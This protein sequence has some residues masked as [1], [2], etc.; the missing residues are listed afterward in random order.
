MSCKIAIYAWKTFNAATGSIWTNNSKYRRGLE[1][2]EHKVNKDIPL[3]RNK[4]N[5]V[6][7]GASSLW[8]RR[9]SSASNPGDR[10]RRPAGQL[11]KL[12]CYHCQGLLSSGCG[13]NTT[14]GGRARTS[15]GLIRVLCTERKYIVTM[16]R[17]C[18]PSWR[19]A[20]FISNVF[21]EKGTGKGTGKV[22]EP[23]TSI[24][25]S[26][27]GTVKYFI[28]DLLWWFTKEL[29][30][31]QGQLMPFH[32]HIYTRTSTCIDVTSEGVTIGNR[33]HWMPKT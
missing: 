31:R 28:L 17:K 32:I 12:P 18:W 14:G 7:V 22:K 23:S 2:W 33:I 15:T 27:Y 19:S 6:H 30:R 3:L 9:S 4:R 26:L 5:F 29:F 25:F 13:V 10:T 21:T 24:C 20:T 1:A 11:L 16:H 8:R